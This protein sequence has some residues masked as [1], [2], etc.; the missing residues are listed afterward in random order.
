MM[1]STISNHFQFQ[2]TTFDRRAAKKK[3]SNNIKCKQRWR[4]HV[5]L[6]SNSVMNQQQQQQPGKCI[7]NNNLKPEIT[8]KWAVFHNQKYPLTK[9]TKDQCAAVA[10]ARARQLY[11]MV[12]LLTIQARCLWYIGT[13]WFD[14]GAFGLTIKCIVSSL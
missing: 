1:S 12:S 4:K 11:C 14:N 5:Y 10:R 9:P 13:H 2:Q 8:R 7:S 6:S 3:A